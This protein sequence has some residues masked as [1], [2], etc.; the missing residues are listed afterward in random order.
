MA[1]AADHPFAPAS[2]GVASP[3]TTVGWVGIAG[4]ASLGAGAIHAAAI[5]V[6]AEHRQAALVFVPVASL[7]LAWGGLALVREGRLVALAGVAL[8]AA[9]VVGWVLAKTAGIAF[10]AGL[11]TPE[12]LQ[13]AD[14]VAAG[15]ALAAVLVATT[16][17]R[18]AA[19]PRRRAD[20]TAAAVAVIGLSMFGMVSGGTHVHASNGADDHHAAEAAGA[21]APASVAPVPYD[22]TKPIDLG[23]S[24]E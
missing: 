15:L 23:A 3:V 11:D 10:V 6:H 14:A 13:S 2:T 4:V 7:Q 21:L 19:R 17:L 1:L 22:P 5:G 18:R 9:A 16:A 8:N 24:R 20:M 12:P